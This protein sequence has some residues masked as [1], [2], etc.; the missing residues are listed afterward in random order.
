[1]ITS[2][3]LEAVHSGATE[4]IVKFSMKDENEGWKQWR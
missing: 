1:M 4:I 3:F 2:I